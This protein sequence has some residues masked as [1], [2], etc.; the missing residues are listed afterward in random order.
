MDLV[1]CQAA[2][3]VIPKRA[4]LVSTAV[5]KADSNG[6]LHY[7]EAYE[8][9]KYRQENPL[10]SLSP[11]P[12]KVPTSNT[13]E[14]VN[15][16]SVSLSTSSITMNVGDTK[17]ISYVVAPSDATNKE[18]G[19]TSSNKSIAYYK[20]GRIVAKSAGVATITVT[21]KSGNRKA[22]VVVNVVGKTEDVV[23][24]SE[25]Y[26]VDV[27]KNTATCDKVVVRNG[28]ATIPDMVVVNGK[29]VKV[30]SVSSKA[31]K[32][33]ASVK[34]I[35]FGKNVTLVSGS[36][37]KFKNLRSVTFKSTKI[38]VGKKSFKTCKKL[39][40]IKFTNK[41]VTKV[42]LGKNAF[43]KKTKLSIQCKSKSAKKAIKKSFRGY[44]VS[45]K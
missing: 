39:K 36:F 41:E 17:A 31:F 6:N 28:V 1:N 37:A 24:N 32:N 3:Y 27:K 43:S 10:E 5:Y 19:W 15:V 18:V 9:V 23:N 45:I 16:E 2:N 40:T 30:T 44:R 35:V 14:V 42:T 33:P 25:D 12:S 38:K 29:K 4:H 34:T 22:S 11:A 26:K 20:D 21:T 7:P 8:S 13:T